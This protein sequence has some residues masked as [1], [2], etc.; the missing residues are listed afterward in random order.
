[1]S[2]LEATVLIPTHDH[3]PL[4]R[5]PIESALAQTVE[6]LEVLVVGD[7]APDITREV[8]TEMASRDPRVRYFDNRKGPRHGELHRHAALAEARGRAV[9][10][11][12]DDDLWLPDHME[13][14]LKLLERVDLVCATCLKVYPDGRL[15]PRFNDLGDPKRR[16][17]LFEDGPG[18]PLSC[19]AHTL[20]AYRKLPYGWRTSPPEISTDK[21]MWRQFLADPACTV[22]GSE[23]L[24]VVALGSAVRLHLTRDERLDELAGWWDRVRSPRGRAELQSELFARTF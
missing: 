7:G 6:S 24:T 2:V 19:A 17:R 20:S 18:I 22:V 8:V 3:G 15:I 11:L 14:M 4:V 1:M 10:Y 13:T 12:A 16:Q 23:R 21:Y 9:L 5:F